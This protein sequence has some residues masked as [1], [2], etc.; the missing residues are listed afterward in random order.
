[1]AIVRG[2]IEIEQWVQQGS[3]TNPNFAL[4]A[5]PLPN[6]RV[7]LTYDQDPTTLAERT[8]ETFTDANGDYSF[9]IESADF[10]F[11]LDNDYRISIPDFS[12]TQD[13]I[14]FTGSIISSVPS[15]FLEESLAGSIE[16]GQVDNA[17]DLL[18]NNF[19]A[20]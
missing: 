8:Y 13:S 5:L 6:Y 14:G 1:M 12:T 17:R 15:V 10:D 4:E 9:S 18:Y 11:N 7:V 20:D 19:I 16:A 2:T 3:I